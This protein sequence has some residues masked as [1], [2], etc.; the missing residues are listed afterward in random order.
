MPQD[1]LKLLPRFN[2]EDN[3]TSQNHI[4]AFYAF[5]NNLN[6]EQLDVVLRIFVRSLD[7]EARKRFKAFPS[8]SNTTWEELENSFTWKW[9][10]KRDHKYALIEFNAIKKKPYEDIS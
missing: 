3:T 1:Y 10:E 7:G 8:A 4:G 6:V 2:G 5:E 9:G